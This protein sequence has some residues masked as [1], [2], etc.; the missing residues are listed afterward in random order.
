M[1]FFQEEKEIDKDGKFITTYLYDDL[2][3]VLRT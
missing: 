3:Y 1:Y 2:K